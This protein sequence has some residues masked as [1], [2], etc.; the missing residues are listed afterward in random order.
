M[1][2]HSEEYLKKHLVGLANWENFLL[3]FSIEGT[4]ESG[5]ECVQSVGSSLFFKS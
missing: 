2:G 5:A 4:A 3:Q 1:H